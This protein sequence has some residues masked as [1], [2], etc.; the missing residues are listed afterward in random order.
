MTE[1]EAR[2]RAALGPVGYAR[3]LADVLDRLDAPGSPYGGASTRAAAPTG[4]E[5]VA[6]GQTIR[7]ATM[8]M[9]LSQGNLCFA[10]A[11]ERD[12]TIPLS[13]R[14]VGMRAHDPTTGYTT[15]SGTAWLSDS[16]VPARGVLSADTTLT[17]G[18]T[19]LITAPTITARPY[20]RILHLSAILRI[21]NATV[22]VAGGNLE[23]SSGLAAG[24]VK[25]VAF[26][27]Q[28][29]TAAGN[30]SAA[31]PTMFAVIPAGAACT[32]KLTGT[33]AGIVVVQSWSYMNILVVRA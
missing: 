6:P 12:A 24:D 14:H 21:N 27:Q 25:S 5:T 11:A 29:G 15:W 33:G 8:N 2:A 20:D 22:P 28:T 30:R 16:S 10:S 7:S 23:L 32:P 9:A 4:W 18:A 26:I 3:L 13:D 31:I 17:A 19:T 1:L